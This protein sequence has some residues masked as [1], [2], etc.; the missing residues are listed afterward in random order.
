MNWEAI[1]AVG[2]VVGAVAVLVTL[3]YLAMQ[4]RQ[5]TDHL[6]QSSEA[7]ILSRRDSVTASFSRWRH[8]LGADAEM[9]E[10]WVRGS[11]D[12][13]SLDLGDDAPAELIDRACLQCHSSG[14]TQGDGIGDEMPLEY[15]DQIKNLAFSREVS[16]TAP[17]IMIASAHTHA[18]GMGTLALLVVLL[19]LATRWPKKI[20]S[21][22]VLLNGLG[23]ALDLGGWFLARS[24]AAWVPVLA[25]GGA[26]WAG[27]SA[28]L[29]GFVL[30]ELW[31]PARK[32]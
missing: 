15:W 8:L 14:A 7:L 11:E 32:E 19:A 2:E 25:V 4:I 29:I 5:N 24:S 3:L 30:L 13:D 28:I 31:L 20:L 23:L 26:I 12:Y 18:L 16:P 9:T 27:T 6:A 1:G 22:L 21:G 17:E 10:I